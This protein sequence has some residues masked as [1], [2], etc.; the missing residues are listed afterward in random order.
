MRGNADAATA[1]AIE[2]GRREGS[3]V[4]NLCP[5]SKKEAIGER[6]PVCGR[7]GAVDGRLRLH[8]PPALKRRRSLAGVD[9]SDPTPNPRG[10]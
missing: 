3:P 8:R 5:G 1:E 2:L 4:I 10:S 7:R 9:E 6:C